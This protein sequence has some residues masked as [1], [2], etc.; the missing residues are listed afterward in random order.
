MLSV[1]NSI[2]Y[3]PKE[4]II[5]AENAHKNFIKPGGDHLRLMNVY[6]QW[7]ETNYSAQWC[8]ESFIQVRSMRRARDIK[9]QLVALCKRV[10]IDYEDESIS[11]VD[12]DVYTNVRKAITSGFFYNTAKLQKSG[13]YRTLKNAHTVHCHP[14]SSMFDALP[15]WVIYHELVLTT[16]EFM[17]SNIDIDPKW[18]LE[19]APHYYKHSD[20]LDEEQ[21]KKDKKLK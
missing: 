16:K 21:T 15:K 12:D 9:E 7:K 8:L 6:E 5:H 18:L 20:I 11:K 13:N 17:R 3:R 1:G 4:K 10:E 19:I 2:F 14:S